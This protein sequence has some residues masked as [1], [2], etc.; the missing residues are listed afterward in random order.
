MTQMAMAL[1]KRV[2]LRASDTTVFIKKSDTTV[3]IR[4]C[5]VYIFV[6]G[7]E[8]VVHIGKPFRLWLSILVDTA[9]VRLGPLGCEMPLLVASFFSFSSHCSSHMVL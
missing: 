8:E 7:N 4:H 2:T 3:C 6:P 9:G 1:N 5:L